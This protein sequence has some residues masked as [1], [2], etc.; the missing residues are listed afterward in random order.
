M[1]A[2]L[3]KEAQA[4]NLKYVSTTIVPKF[5]LQTWKMYIPEA[6][7]RLL[8]LF[9]STYPDAYPEIVGTVNESETDPCSDDTATQLGPRDEAFALLAKG[10]PRGALPAWTSLPGKMDQSNSKKL[11]RL[12]QK[13]GC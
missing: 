7:C 6:L 10:N 8:I 13:T 4:I 9:P 11:K 1:P 12:S 3:Y 5:E 2:I